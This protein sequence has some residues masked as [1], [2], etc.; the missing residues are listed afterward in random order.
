M[1]VVFF[2]F[3]AFILLC[4]GVGFFIASL[5]IKNKYVKYIFRIVA[6]LFAG[7][8][9]SWIISIIFANITATI[10]IGQNLG[11]YLY[12]III[13]A[14]GILGYVLYKLFRFHLSKETY[15]KPLSR[16]LIFLLYLN[17]LCDMFPILFFIM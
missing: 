12:F 5:K 3:F 13:N 4:I 1:G 8:M 2:L 15:D 9:S 10:H 16:F 11:I 6:M 17:I 7:I 14:L